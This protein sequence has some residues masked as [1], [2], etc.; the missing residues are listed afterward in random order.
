VSYNRIESCVATAY[1]IL[2]G[3][4]NAGFGPAVTE[5]VSEAELKLRAIGSED[6]GGGGGGSITDGAGDGLESGS[7]S[8]GIG[9]SADEVSIVMCFVVG[10]DVLRV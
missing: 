8:D 4:A 10:G 5:P 9:S 3:S 2:Y 7:G 1:T 6:G